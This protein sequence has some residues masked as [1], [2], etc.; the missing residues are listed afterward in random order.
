[1]PASWKGL[2]LKD[3]T[4]LRRNIETNSQRTTYQVVVPK[5]YQKPLL[6]QY[7]DSITAGHLGVAKVYNKIQNKYF[8]SR[9]KDSIQLYVKTCISCQKKKHP[10]RS[11]CDPLQKYVVGTPFERVALDIMGTL[12]ETE[13][14]NIYILVVTDYFTRW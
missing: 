7:H 13:R 4:I 10:P 8:W 12:C 2:I 9:M 5:V 6:Y 3:D 11:F 14:G 1:M